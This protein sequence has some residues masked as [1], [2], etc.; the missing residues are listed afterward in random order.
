MTCDLKWRENHDCNNTEENKITAFVLGQQ[1]PADFCTKDTHIHEHVHMCHI[2]CMF[3]RQRISAVY[4][5]IFISQSHTTMMV[6]T[7][8][9]AARRACTS[10]CPATHSEQHA[11]EV[12]SSDI[13]MFL[14]LTGSLVPAHSAAAA[15]QTTACQTLIHQCRDRGYSTAAPSDVND[16]V[17]GQT[18]VRISCWNR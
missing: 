18:C 10:S 14:S 6:A 5:F 3:Y 15:S 17:R 4:W 16:W 11:A 2:M 13:Q 9:H 7:A 12:E 1:T 8:C